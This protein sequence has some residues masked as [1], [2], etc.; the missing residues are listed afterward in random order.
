MKPMH[1]SVNNTL[2]QMSF[3][4]GFSTTKASLKPNF[5]SD[6]GFMGELG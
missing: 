2:A 3:H 6:T 5:S 1:I 4:F